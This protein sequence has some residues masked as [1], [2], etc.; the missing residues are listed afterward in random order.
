MEELIKLGV[1]GKSQYSESNGVHPDTYG[2]QEVRNFFIG[3]VVS[4]DEYADVC[5]GELVD[6]F[7]MIDWS[8]R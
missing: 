3:N 5:Y 6:D 2:C 1:C 8:E 7:Q 4:D